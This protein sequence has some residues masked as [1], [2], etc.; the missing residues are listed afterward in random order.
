MLAKLAKS[1]HSK[2]DGKFMTTTRKTSQTTSSEGSDEANQGAG[3]D[4]IPLKAVT[5]RVRE[6]NE[7]ATQ[8]Y[9]EVGLAGVGA[10]DRAIKAVADLEN[11]TA[12]AA[13]V[14]WVE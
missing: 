6:F 13:K 8:S 10:Y 3:W 11:R 5:D 1:C 14:A 12:S 4:R 7:R 9:R 2:T